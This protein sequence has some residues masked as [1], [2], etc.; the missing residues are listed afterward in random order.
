MAKHK[1][2]HWLLNIY[3]PKYHNN[4]YNIVY[5]KQVT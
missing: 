1:N 4:V 3:P 5:N 2:G